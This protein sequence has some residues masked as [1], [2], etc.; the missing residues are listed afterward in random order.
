MIRKLIAALVLVLFW[1]AFDYALVHGAEL[2]L[3]TAG[4][5][6]ADPQPYFKGANQ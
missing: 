3:V 1:I 4:Q 2:E 6:Y 5:P